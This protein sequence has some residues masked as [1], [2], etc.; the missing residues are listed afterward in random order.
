MKLTRF[1][2]VAL[3]A[4]SFWGQGQAFYLQIPEGVKLPKDSLE[5]Q[6]LTESLDRFLQ[7]TALYNKFVKPEAKEET[8]ILLSEIEAIKKQQHGNTNLKPYLTNLIPIGKTDYMAELS[9]M[10]VEK[11]QAVLYAIVNFI[12]TPSDTGFLFASPLQY[13]TQGWHGIQG[14]Y[15]SAYCQD[16]DNKAY[17]IQYFKYAKQFDELLGSSF[18]TT[19]YYCK[20]CNTL[21]DLL[22]LIGLTYSKLYGGENWSMID[23]I[24]AKN[25]YALYTKSFFDGKAID[26]HDVFHSRAY[27][28]IPPEKRNRYMI[29]GCAYIY[30]GSWLISWK[31]IQRKFKEKIDYK[32]EKDW[33]K[34]YFD[35][36]DFGD[37]KAEHL[38]VTQFVNALI[39]EKAV[40]E[41]GF[42]EAKKLLA[43]GNMYKERESFFKILE[44]ITGINEKNFNQEVAK[45]IETAM[46]DISAN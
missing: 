11:E 27:T 40:K 5:C 12:A 13:N 46:Q 19:N 14:D 3:S 33:L 26:P 29:C 44:E 16:E 30:A 25:K 36:Y 42:A 38:L 43:S 34:L 45:I 35:R 21:P 4:F 20:S 10:G 9:F 7:D 39:I 28:V 31:D 41:K 17:A 22:R 18:P 37:S 32:K 15:L 1:F 24:E 8:A 23:F 6:Y 2:L